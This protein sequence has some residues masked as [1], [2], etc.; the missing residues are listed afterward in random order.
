MFPKNKR[1]TQLMLRVTVIL[2]FKSDK[3]ITRKEVIN[4]YS[5][6]TQMQK[7]LTNYH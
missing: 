3:D 5:S 2:T 4:Q 1:E 6:P 7:F